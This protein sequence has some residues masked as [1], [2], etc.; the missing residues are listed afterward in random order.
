MKQEERKRERE[1]T[2]VRAKN[3]QAETQVS[4]IFGGD[5]EAWELGFKNGNRDL[6]LS[7][8]VVVLT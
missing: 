1:G 4:E 2:I 6:G 8:T 5:G 7:V 3:K